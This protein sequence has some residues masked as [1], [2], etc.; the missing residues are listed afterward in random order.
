MKN[1][2]LTGSTGFVGKQI[3]KA[4][5]N[6]KMSTIHVCRP[7]NEKALKDISKIQKII[8]SKDI[9][10]ED[11]YWWEEQCKDIDIVIHNAWYM[12]DDHKESSKNIDCLKGSLN[13]VSGA[14]KAGVKRFVGIGTCFEYD[15][16]K[17]VLSVDTPLKPSTHVF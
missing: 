17:K 7:G 8:K 10:Q 1:I 9:F 16:T 6:K 5:A 14:I 12:D 15:L 11:E 3:A 2:L 4:L 13:L